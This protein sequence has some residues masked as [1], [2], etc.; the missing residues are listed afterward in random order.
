MLVRAERI[1]TAATLLVLS[2]AAADDEGVDVQLS[3]GV[4]RGVKVSLQNSRH[5][6]SFKGIPYGKPPVGDL[7]YKDPVEAEGWT[8]VRE[9]ST[10]PECPQQSLGHFYGNKT[11]SL[12][13]EDCLYLNVYTPD[14]HASDLPVMVY[15]HGGGFIM[16]N[17]DTFG[18]SPNRL[19]TKN[20]V[21][22][23]IQYR[24]GVLGFLS[25]GDDVIPGNFGLKDQTLALQWVHKNIHT[26]GGDP[27][28]VTIFGESAGA[29]SVHMHILSPMSAGLF[30]RAIM[31]SGSALCP[32]TLRNDHR[33]MAAKLGQRFNCAGVSS[34]TVQD[35][36]ELLNCLKGLPANE[37]VKINSE[38]AEWYYL[39]FAMVPRVDGEFLPDHPA[40]ILRDGV[41]NKV[42]IIS[43]TNLHEGAH[44]YTF[45]QDEIAKALKERFSD[46]GPL[47]LNTDLEQFPEY[48]S[49]RILHKYLGRNLTLTEDN[50]EKMI[51][52]FTDQFIAVHEEVASQ[53]HAKNADGENV[54]MYQMEYRGEHSITEIFSPN[55]TS[56]WVAHGDDL[57]YL[58][59]DV[60][61]IPPLEAPE[62]VFFS[63]IMLT[64][65]TNFATTGMP[66]HDYSMGFMWKPI[67]PSCL[68]YLSLSLVPTMKP[69]TNAEIRKFYQDLPTLQNTILH[70]E[71][72]SAQDT[73]ECVS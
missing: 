71:R 50:K 69:D 34:E 28:K 17:P 39:P 58:F 52:V 30:K 13:N 48:L 60:M 20:I 42:D 21:L 31:Q 8:G 10:P 2:C 38:M 25:T 18:G 22:V 61:Y 68:Q 65:W 37:L 33:R 63:D 51:Q 1:V 27:E 15:I 57:I 72:P 29:S 6:Y 36:L 5:F 46:V 53:I 9:S 3:Q 49:R 35:S 55:E 73:H 12:G 7:R 54:F 26:L 45:F 24:L 56:N 59:T 43:G 62:D 19:L 41:Y 14:P 64:L 40:A 66:T 67:S 47:L 4:I 44:I 23:S 11:E 16:G 32:W 70:P